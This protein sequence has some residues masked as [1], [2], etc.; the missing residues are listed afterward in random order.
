MRSAGER[1][2][3]FGRSGRLK[4]ILTLPAGATPSRVLALVNAG[5]V[6]KYGPY[7]IYTQVARRLASRGL[8]VLRFDLGGLGDSVP[9]AAGVLRE[10]TLTDLRA[11][12]DLLTDEFPG[13]ELTFGGICSAAEDSLRFAETDTRV[14]RLILIDPFAYRTR[15]FAW[16]HQRHRLWRRTLRSLGLWWPGPRIASSIIDYRYM[17]RAESGRILATL[18]AR[19]ARL[20]FVYTGGRRE[21]FNHPA[22]LGRMFPHLDLGVVATLD[23]LPDLD[24]TQFLQGERDILIATCER[25]LASAP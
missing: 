1:A 15:G 19:G 5:F 21:T 16:R 6:P 18:I 11:A 4:G 3:S 22:Q 20:H 12:A 7:R 9:S 2:V 17:E 24:H 10:R 23:Y 13:A 25:R 8:A 14:S